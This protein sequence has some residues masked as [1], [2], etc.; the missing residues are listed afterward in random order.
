MTD[1]VVKSASFKLMSVPKC[2][3]SFQFIIFVCFIV[4]VMR[5]P[6]KF[7][8]SILKFNKNC[9]R[10]CFRASRLNWKIV[11][12]I[13]E[14]MW[15]SAFTLKSIE[16]RLNTFFILST[17]FQLSVFASIEF[18]ETNYQFSSLNAKDRISKV[19]TKAFVACFL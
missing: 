8:C 10:Q 3:E 1:I 5:W 6:K 14:S 18:R 12:R 11:H 2:E 13:P 4:N 7:L 16:K 17:I 19:L 15:S 9:T